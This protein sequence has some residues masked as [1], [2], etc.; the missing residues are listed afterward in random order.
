M[1]CI[2]HYQVVMDRLSCLHL[3][4]AHGGRHSVSGKLATNIGS[5]R[6]KMTQNFMSE[7]INFTLSY[8]SDYGVPTF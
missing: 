5:R 6:L 8:Y 2:G 4:A 7:L 1:Q 3:R